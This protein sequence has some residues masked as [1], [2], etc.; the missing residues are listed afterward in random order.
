MDLISTARALDD[1]NLRWRVMA[2]CIEHAQTFQQ[3]SG[4]PRNFAVTVLLNP[5]NV[6]MSMVAIVAADDIIADT[7]TVSDTGT[8]DTSAVTDEDIMRVVVDKW[9][10]VSHKYP[11]DPLSPSNGNGNQ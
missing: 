11:R 5:Q 1:M 4:N 10:L 8:V 7:I 2:A 6:D 9:P 3:M